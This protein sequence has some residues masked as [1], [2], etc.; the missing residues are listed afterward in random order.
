MRSASLKFLALRAALRASMSLI[1]TSSKPLDVLRAFSRFHC[2]PSEE[3]C[4]IKAQERP[5]SEPVP[6]HTA[7]SWVTNAD[8]FDHMQLC[9]SQRLDHQ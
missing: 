9:N 3:A 8:F 2:F 1:A 5:N 4:A 6:R 7:N